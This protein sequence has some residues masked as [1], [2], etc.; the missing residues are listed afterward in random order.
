[1]SDATPPQYANQRTDAS[2]RKL[3]EHVDDCKAE[4]TAL[5]EVYA[6]QALEVAAM[7]VRL[8]QAPTFRAALGGAAG[9]LVLLL[10]VFGSVV[11]RTESIANA[12]GAQALEVAQRASAS[13][14]RATARAE[15]TETLVKTEVQDFRREIRTALG[16]LTAEVRNSTRAV[17]RATR[18]RDGGQ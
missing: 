13:A 4:V 2:T 3:I 15:S 16:E 5:R 7:K 18:R 11:S 6:E 14:E 1:M 12:A 10:G 9:I 8:E 17:D